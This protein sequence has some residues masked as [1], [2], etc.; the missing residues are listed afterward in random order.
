MPCDVSVCG[1]HGEYLLEHAPVRNVSQW[2]EGINIPPGYSRSGSLPI[3][4]GTMG[5]D[6]SC[7]HEDDITQVLS[8]QL[9]SSL[10]SNQRRKFK[11]KNNNNNKQQI[12]GNSGGR[13][14]SRTERII[15][16]FET[17][18]KIVRD[19]REAAL[20]KAHDVS[21]TRIET[22]LSPRDPFVQWE[23]TYPFRG[24]LMYDS[25]TGTRKETRGIASIVKR[26]LCD[27]ESEQTVI[28]DF[29][30]LCLEQQ[31][32]LQTQMEESVAMCTL[33]IEECQSNCSC[34]LSS[35][36]NTD[37]H[38]ELNS[39]L[40]NEINENQSLNI[41]TVTIAAIILF[42]M[43]ILGLFICCLMLGFGSR[44]FRFRTDPL[45][46]EGLGFQ[47]S[48]NRTMEFAGAKMPSSQNTSGTSE[49]PSQ[50]ARRRHRSNDR[51]GHRSAQRRR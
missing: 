2:M 44:R 24:A 34:S 33:S 29:L 8:E 36:T 47:G 43:I 41:A 12:D 38:E 9:R 18:R 40:K 19:T 30:L 31:I 45:S 49:L 51:S 25:A 22:K 16:D 7:R 37:E 4:P 27:T 50:R 11:F 28:E 23:G 20:K 3:M 21:K 13:S 42:G 48:Q 32:T 5:V 10:P 39:D 1:V 15:A 6:C 46:R 35:T 26:D 14:P 17:Q